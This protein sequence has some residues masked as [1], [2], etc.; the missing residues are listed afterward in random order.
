M[1]LRAVQRSMEK[2]EFKE[3]PIPEYLIE[4]PNNTQHGHFATNLPLV[5][6]PCKNGGLWIWPR[7]L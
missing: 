3:T 5:M 2:G 6:A 7:A 4:V 1:L